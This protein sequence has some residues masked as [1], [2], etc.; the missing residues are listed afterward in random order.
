MNFCVECGSKLQHQAKFCVNCGTKI[1]SSNGDEKSSN[2]APPKKSSA[3]N[4]DMAAGRMAQVNTRIKLV[5]GNGFKHGEHCFNCGAKISNSR[6]CE[7]C[8][9]IQK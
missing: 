4:M 7:T 1:A 9:A 6:K 3:I 8:D 5:Y 2:L